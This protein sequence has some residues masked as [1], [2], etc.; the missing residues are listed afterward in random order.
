MAEKITS[1][2]IADM[3]F[4]RASSDRK[5]VQQGAEFDEK[6]KLT[7]P[8]FKIEEIKANEDPI[9]FKIKSDEAEKAH[10]EIKQRLDELRL[11][12][13][14]LTKEKDA[15]FEPYNEA[16]KASAD[17][18]EKYGSYI[19]EYGHTPFI[20]GFEAW[21]QYRQGKDQKGYGYKL[22]EWNAL[23][24]AVEKLDEFEQTEYT[25]LEEEYQRAFGTLSDTKHKYNV[26]LRNAR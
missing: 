19:A 22:P 14:E 21:E 1:E 6:G 10:N 8:Q 25:P 7:V 15:A 13:K 9:E 3:N 4:E 5:L 26:A 12:Y 16:L 24:N 18:Q 11:K 20:A 17:Y 23:N 2:E